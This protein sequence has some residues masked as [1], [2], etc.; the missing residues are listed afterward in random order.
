MNAFFLIVPA[1]VLYGLAYRMYSRRLANAFG[2]D[3]A[4][5][6]PA[7]TR[8]DGVDYVP[9]RP[10]VLF[11][12]H[13]SAI[14]AAGPILGPTWAILYGYAPGVVWI[15]LGAILIGAVHDYA[16]LYVSVREGGRSIAEIAR[17]MMGN[18][19][20][21][22]YALFIVFN[23]VVVNAVFI[24]V[25]AASLTSRTPLSEL[26]L[27]PD[28]H[29]FRTEAGPGGARVALVGGIASTSAIV[30]TILAP[31][32]GVLIVKRGMRERFSYPLA[33][34]L[35]IGSV[36]V[37]FLLPVAPPA[38][39]VGSYL[40]TPAQLWVV[41][42]AL[43]VWLAAAV[44]VWLILQP[45]EFVSVQFL[46]LGIG[47]LAVAAVAAGI[48]GLPFQA[49]P[50][51]LATGP[52]QLGALWPVLFVTIACGAVSGFH[53]LVASGTTAK[54]VSLESHS[55]PVGYAGMLGESMLAL[56][57]T[58]ALAVGLSPSGY[59]GTLLPPP[60]A[61]PGWPSNPVLAF[62]LGVAGVCEM[63]LGIP[64]W[65]GLLFGLLMVEGF[66]LD[67]LDVSIRLNRYLLEEIWSVLFRDVP[68]FLRN[69]WV[70]SG[71]S[72]AL[73]LLLAFTQA[74]SLLWP[75]FGTGNQLL[76]SLSLVCVTLWLAANGRPTW[77]TLVP[78]VLVGVTSLASLS[79]LLLARY[80]PTGRY[81]LAVTTVAFMLLALGVLFFALRTW[82][83]VRRAPERSAALPQRR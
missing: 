49:P 14:A 83:A 56:C 25:T 38:I 65:L 18:G 48:R 19:A 35:C 23:L 3:D 46:Y 22:L 58:I 9:T 43:Y 64:R 80:L 2:Q 31:I 13:F 71:A 63:G 61:T 41:L 59:V 76:A 4:R 47:L 57:V 20:F 66:V 7:V 8:N 50:T 72:V 42:I 82:R 79:Y 10:H 24:N 26:G 28:Q 15:V 67:T 37:G 34:V 36:L 27:T 1:I 73:M 52:Q 44:P 77:Y 30:L 54:Q 16:C 45:R 81:V 6:T 29:M 70:N 62:S 21:V 68:P 11:A 55:R 12:H 69:Y 51:D 53:G 74:G 32:L 5:P 60:D 17:R 33:T 78:A 39:H 75:V 40:I